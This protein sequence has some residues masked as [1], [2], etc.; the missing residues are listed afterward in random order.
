[1]TANTLLG[2][3]TPPRAHGVRSTSGTGS[4]EMRPQAKLFLLLEPAGAEAPVPESVPRQTEPLWTQLPRACQRVP[5]GD[6]ES[7]G[8]GPAP[9]EW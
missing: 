9:S 5:G 3:G 4:Q 6:M 8:P 1:M 2:S 7:C